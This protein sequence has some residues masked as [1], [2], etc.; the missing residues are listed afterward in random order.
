MKAH[1]RTC[2]TRVV[3]PVAVLCGI[4]ATPSVAEKNC[5]E[6]FSG[7]GCPWKS[8]LK[9]AELR[10]LACDDLAFMRNRI[11]KE[12][13]YCFR[14]PAVKAKLGNEGCKFPLQQV[15]PLNAYEKA[16]IAAIRKIEGAKRCK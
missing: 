16:N 1:I 6:G 12:N 13:G 9:D 2:L 8:Y 14:D 4:A 5:Y 7:G 15:V 10:G 3:L 11:Y